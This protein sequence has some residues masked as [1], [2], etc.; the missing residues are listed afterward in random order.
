MTRLTDK[1][2][3]YAVKNGIDFNESF[4][5]SWP[6]QYGPTSFSSSGQQVLNTNNG[7]TATANDGPFPGQYSWRFE[8]GKGQGKA[9]RLRWTSAGNESNVGGN[10]VRPQN[11]TYSIWVRI[12]SMDANPFY[13]RAFAEYTN[14]TGNGNPGSDDDW[15]MGW[16]MGYIK[17]NDAGQPN[18]GKPIL[19]LYTGYQ[20][21]YIA[22]DH[23]GNF[24][25]YGKWY[26]ATIRK[27]KINSTTVEVQFM[28]NGVVKATRTHTYG[29]NAM[30]VYDHGQSTT[31]IW[32]DHSLGCSFLGENTVFTQSVIADIYKYGSPIQVPVKYYDGSAW[33]TSTGHKV[34][35]G[36]KWIDWYA[37]KWD[38]SA[39]IPI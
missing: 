14:Y 36:S 18:Y 1:I 37:S 10:W 29:D 39:W 26:L 7:L 8:N 24:L 22:D 28:I 16:Y 17:Q 34:Y 4:T 2:H 12:N 19:N 30:A 38:G 23:N 13:N 3:S 5:G 9:A 35:D 32:V 11:F 20:D 31:T 15:Y 33:Q 27:T 21:I 25:D 6:S